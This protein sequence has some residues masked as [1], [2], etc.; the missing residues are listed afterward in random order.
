MHALNLITGKQY[1][2]YSRCLYCN[3]ICMLQNMMMEES[4]S[5]KEIRK[6]QYCIK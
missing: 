6:E 5:L 3:A 2:F 4:F 1:K